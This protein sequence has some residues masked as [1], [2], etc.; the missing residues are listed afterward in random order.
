MWRVAIIRLNWTHMALINWFNLAK[1]AIWELN[2]LIQITLIC[3]IH[4]QGRKTKHFCLFTYILIATT[5]RA[6]I[7]YR[8]TADDEIEKYKTYRRIFKCCMHMRAKHSHEFKIHICVYASPIWFVCY[9][10]ASLQQLALS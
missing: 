10:T 7:S 1:R 2:V 8:Y 9:S 6:P 5:F 3:I 4:V